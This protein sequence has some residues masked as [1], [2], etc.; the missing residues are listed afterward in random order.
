MD[1]SLRS[2]D[3]LEKALEIPVLGMV[4]RLTRSK[5]RNPGAY[6]RENPAST[7]AQGLRDIVHATRAGTV[8]TGWN[9]ILVTST[10][11]GEGKTTFCEAFAVQLARMGRRVLII[12]GDLRRRDTSR[13]APGGGTDL[14]T[15]LERGL[16]Y[17]GV[18]RHD[19]RLGVDIAPTF[20]F[21]PEPD[22]LLNSEQMQQFIT[23]ASHDYDTVIID[24]PPIGAV[25]DAAILAA[26][27]AHCIYLVQWGKTPKDAVLAGLR[28]LHKFDG[29]I[30]VRS[31]LT[32]VHI[33]RYANYDKGTYSPY[34]AK[35]QSYFR[36]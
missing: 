22:S 12:D 16:P 27:A 15:M 18:V 13:R 32:Q 4:P 28:K 35:Y 30:K 25:H 33:R 24:S 34:G 21:T 10:A 36:N 3:S 7:F 6:L 1:G 14:K 29:Q 9:V 8:S 2:L 20:S 23:I 31:V 19:P 17:D 5:A 26:M 11:P